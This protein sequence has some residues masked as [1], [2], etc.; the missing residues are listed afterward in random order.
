ML[1]QLDKTAAVFGGSIIRDLKAFRRAV[2]AKLRRAYSSQAPGSL[3]LGQLRICCAGK[4]YCRR[5]R[6]EAT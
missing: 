3:K 2:R 1:E 5:G 4:K 6:L